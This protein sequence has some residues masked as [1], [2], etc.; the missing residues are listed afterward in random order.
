V[1]R[2]GANDM[3][4]VSRM[5]GTVVLEQQE[6]AIRK[7]CKRLNSQPQLD[8]ARRKPCEIRA[9]ELGILLMPLCLFL[10][11]ATRKPG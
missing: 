6:C 7:S 1:K 3:R 5:K 9:K 8:P 11:T 2:I 10:A 4:L